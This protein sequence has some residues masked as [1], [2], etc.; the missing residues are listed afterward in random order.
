MTKAKIAKQPT[1]KF[2]EVECRKCG[3]KA[4]VFNRAAT[5]V[6]CKCGDVLVEPAG[7]FAHITGKVVKEL[8]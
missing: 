1:S 4:I 3:E 7:G 5:R 8:D 2:V 6:L